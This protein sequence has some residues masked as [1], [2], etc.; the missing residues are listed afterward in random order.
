M[1]VISLQSGSSGNCTYVES[2]GVRLLFDAGISG[3]QAEQ[4]LAEH[5]KEIRDVDALIISHDHS[6]HTCGMGIY[7]RKFG[8]P[9]YT[10]RRTYEATRRRMKLGNV[11]DVRF[12]AAGETL[13]F[14]HVSVETICTPHDAADGVAFVLDD[15]LHR[16]GVLTDLGHVF[17]ELLHAIGSLDAVLIESNYDVSMLRRGPYPE[18]LKTRISG[19]KGH[20][21][22]H[23][24]AHLLKQAASPKLQWACL[25]HLS[26]ENNEPELAIET[27][28]EILGADFP[29]TC[30]DRRNATDVLR[31]SDSCDTMKREAASPVVTQQAF[32]W[33][34]Q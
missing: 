12:F 17:N 34:D 27:H 19:P 21:S 7:Q 13:T 1:D 33:A 31:V 2:D 23:D 3:R 6:D 22:N 4:R 9:I 15:A 18:F 29:L 20:L 8:L 5:G 25:A 28:H 16:F 32:A 30:A 26:D 10:T 24:A 14:D 11:N